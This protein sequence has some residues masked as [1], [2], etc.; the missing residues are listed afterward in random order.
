MTKRLGSALHTPLA[1]CVIVAV[2]FVATALF[3]LN[4]IRSNIG[5]TGTGAT[6]LGFYALILFGL[7]GLWLLAY[8]AMIGKLRRFS[9]GRTGMNASFVTELNK[10]VSDEARGLEITPD[11]IRKAEMASAP[12]NGLEGGPSSEPGWQTLV[13]G[14]YRGLSSPVQHS[15]Q[16]RGGP[17]GLVSPA[18]TGAGATRTGFW[19]S[20]DISDEVMVVMVGEEVK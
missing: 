16:A 8:L 19:S 11:D 10:P 4:P 12:R 1:Q 6:A 18:R 5:I 20:L 15:R 3:L 9:V 14:S 7:P 17:T 2:I 13:S